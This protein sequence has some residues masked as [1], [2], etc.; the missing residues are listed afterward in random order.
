MQQADRKRKAPEKEIRSGIFFPLLVAGI[1][2][3][4]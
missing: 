4:L 1:Y 2:G 3:R